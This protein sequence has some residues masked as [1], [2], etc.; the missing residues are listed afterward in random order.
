MI[1]IQEEGFYDWFPEAKEMLL[2]NNADSRNYLAGL[3][4]ELDLLFYKNAS[5]NNSLVI[6]T[7]RDEHLLAGY[8]VSY[9]GTNPHSLGTL[10]GF[11]EALYVRPEY[12]GKGLGAKLLKSSEKE[13]VKKGAKV[14][15]LY[16]TGSGA[17]HRSM[18][19]TGGERLYMKILEA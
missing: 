10:F 2:Q 3:P 17:L 12:R 15:C 7:A 14:G 1:T 16:T 8:H 6:M 4:W 9:I 5:T 18:G 13:W 11:D 19:Y